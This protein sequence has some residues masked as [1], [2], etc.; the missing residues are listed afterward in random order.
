MDLF[1]HFSLA[2]LRCFSL[3]GAQPFR[4]G[5]HVEIFVHYEEFPGPYISLSMSSFLYFTMPAACQMTGRKYLWY[6]HTAIFLTYFHVTVGYQDIHRY[7]IL[8]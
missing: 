5:L 1:Y 8:K 4:I 6:E 7:E 2:F 3:A